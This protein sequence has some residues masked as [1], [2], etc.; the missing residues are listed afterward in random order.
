MNLLPNVDGTYEQGSVCADNQTCLPMTLSF[1]ESVAYSICFFLDKH[2]CLRLYVISTRL[3]SQR[4]LL[5]SM[6]QRRSKACVSLTV[7]HTMSRVE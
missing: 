2:V 3:S 4:Q 7:L 1:E 6:G 5:Y